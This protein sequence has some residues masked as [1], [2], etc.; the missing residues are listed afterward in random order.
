M[1]NAQTH[2]Y[3]SESDKTDGVDLSSYASF[4]KTF[5]L[6]GDHLFS[7]LFE[8]HSDVVQTEKE[9]FAVAN[10]NKIL[11]AT[12]DISSK[13]GFDKMSLRDLSKRAGMSMGAIYSCI[14]KKEDIALMVADI[15]RLSSESTIKQT[16]KFETVREQL[17]QTIRFNLYSTTLLQPWY[18]FLYF[19][20]RTLPI[21]QQNESKKIETTAIQFFKELIDR[22]IDSG[23]FQCDEPSVVANMIVVLIQDWYL[24]PW[25]Y[26]AFG[27]NSVNQEKAIEDFYCSM[28]KNIETLL[29]I[30][31][32]P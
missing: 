24:K 6:Q 14:S 22:G 11:D 3:D 7:T 32:R 8:R 20:T 28:I 19:E 16:K 4:L 18:F 21:Q 5:P 1:L 13:S 31:T 29:S 27:V 26:K 12:F 30:G 9:K 17:E 15:V 25:K 2:H 23:E 10:L